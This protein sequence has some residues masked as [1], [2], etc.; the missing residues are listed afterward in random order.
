MKKILLFGTLFFSISS[1][2]QQNLDLKLELFFNVNRS[3]LTKFHLMLLD[4]AFMGK[5]LVVTTIKGFADSTGNASYNLD[6]S[7]KRTEAVFQYF[8]SHHYPDSINVQYYGEQNSAGSELA[9]DRRVEIW[10]RQKEVEKV[11]EVEEKIQ[12][13][14]LAITEKYEISNIYFLPDKAIVDPT[15]FFVIDDAA[16]YLKRFSGC[17]FEIVG[18]VNYVTPPSLAND[19][20]A[21]VPLQILSEERAKEIYDQLAERGIPIQDMTHKGV[22]NSQMVFKNPKNDHKKRKNMRVE[23]LISCKK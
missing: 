21:L 12:A 19:P 3:V 9:Y 4:S 5:N 6:L 20:K 23:I 7:K 10:F 13:D 15:S 17:K 14:T 8:V 22:G 2:S 1:F 16:K 18:H 11:I